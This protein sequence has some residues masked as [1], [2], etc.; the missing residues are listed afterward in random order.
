MSRSW[1]VRVELVLL[2]AGLLVMFA[3]VTWGSE[4]ANA[5]LRAQGGG[6]DGSQFMIVFEK[7]IDAY[8]WIG[9]ILS[10]VG[11]VGVVRAV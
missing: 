11:G 8:R 10:L 2:V 4:A 7:Y 3:S 9:R 1:L 5:Y 6:M